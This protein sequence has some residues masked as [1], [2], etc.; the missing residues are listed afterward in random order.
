MADAEAAQAAAIG[1]PPTHTVAGKGGE[2]H[3]SYG[4]TPGSRRRAVLAK[5]TDRRQQMALAEIYYAQRSLLLTTP[6]LAVT[7]ISG[8]LS[9]LASS[10]VVKDDDVTY[11]S[12][13]AGMLA[14]IAAVLQAVKQLFAWDLKSENFS[15]VAKMLRLLEARIDLSLITDGTETA[16]EDFWDKI[17]DDYLD[18]EKIQKYALPVDKL[19]KWRAAM[20]VE[21][22]DDDDDDLPAWLAPYRA[23]LGEMGIIYGKDIVYADPAELEK[24]GIPVATIITMRAWMR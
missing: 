15:T 3:D 10:S 5:I 16:T 20:L 13:T 1:S 11:I 8:L 18:I 6:V 2:C 24:V 14:S 12:L 21:N 19:A 23:L 4:R 22:N 7:A 9:F 17:Q